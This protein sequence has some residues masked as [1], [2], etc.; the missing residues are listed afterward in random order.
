M[1]LI[2]YIM[3]GLL[4]L[5]VVGIVFVGISK[6]S[7]YKN[8]KLTVLYDQ[9]VE[10]VISNSNANNKTYSVRDGYLVETKKV[11]IFLEVIDKKKNEFIGTLHIRYV[12]DKFK[13]A[14]MIKENLK[15]TGKKKKDN[16]WRI[17]IVDQDYRAFST[18]GQLKEHSFAF[19]QLPL[20]EKQS[21]TLKANDSA[22]YSKVV[23]ELSKTLNER[24]VANQKNYFA[25]V[26]NKKLKSELNNTLSS[27]PVN[28]VDDIE[29]GKTKIYIHEAYLQEVAKRIETNFYKIDNTHK[30]LQK[31]ITTNS[32]LLD[33][34]FET[35]VK[36]YFTEIST[37]DDEIKQ[38]LSYYE[39]VT[40]FYETTN[41]NKQSTYS[42]SDKETADLLKNLMKTYGN[43][44]LK[45]FSKKISSQKTI[46]DRLYT[47]A[48]KKIN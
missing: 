16:N 23:N 35:N 7:A 24:N 20:L 46:T 19:T 21:Y 45:Q 6:W 48:G 11:I 26:E 1:K 18:M 37:I 30:S 13:T 44:K 5:I 10:N 17:S 41:E 3:I 2:K 33:S 47:L 29:K 12:E 14:K 15:I 4:F 39:N 43:E 8:A 42:M 32:P 40:S 34:S 36:S 28:V 25:N 9:E 31:Y 27:Y 22:Y 38:L